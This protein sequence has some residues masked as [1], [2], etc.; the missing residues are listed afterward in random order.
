MELPYLL[1]AT[2]HDPKLYV[3]S[4]VAVYLS[5]SEALELLFLGKNTDKLE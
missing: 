4:I 3:D 1:E 5:P 2:V